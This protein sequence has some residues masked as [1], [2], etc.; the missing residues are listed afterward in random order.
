V[1]HVEVGVSAD[2]VSGLGLIPLFEYSIEVL[3]LYYCIIPLNIKVFSED[4]LKLFLHLFNL[5]GQ[6]E[7]LLRTE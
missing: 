4:F 2:T 1:V 3:L 5:V 6:V 7:A